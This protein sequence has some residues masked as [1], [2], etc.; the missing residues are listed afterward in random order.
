MAEEDQL[1]PTAK[2]EGYIVYTRLGYGGFDNGVYI[3]QP[4]YTVEVEPG[5]TYSFKVTAV[6]KGG[7]SFPSEILSAYIA[8]KS[9]GTVMIV[10]GFHATSGPA[11]INSD[12]RQGFDLASDPGIP[13]INS[14]SFCGYQQVFDKKKIGK[15]TQD[16]LGYSGKELEG[17]VVAGNTFDYPFVHGKSIQRAGGYSFV[18]CSSETLESGS[19][20]LDGYCMVDYIL[21]G[22]KGVLTESIKGSL[23]GYCAAGGK[24][25]IS[26]EH[27]GTSTNDE[28]FLRGVLQCQYQGN[29]SGNKSGE[30]RGSNINFSIPRYANESVYA[31]PSPEI[32]RPLGDAYSVYLFSDNRSAGVASPS[33]GTF[34]LGFPFECITDTRSRDYI[35][36][37]AMNLLLK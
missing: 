17:K 1:E 18:S 3:S 35:M 25:F 14:A 6:N 31:V 36:K 10:N 21:G 30:I 23:R 11:E 12:S 24:L 37:A 7:E 19:T 15:E 9:K 4:E 26:G 27:L 20:R 34:A 2:P 13:Y 29:M 8:K 33:G 32:I 28:E 16:G 22:E 5:L